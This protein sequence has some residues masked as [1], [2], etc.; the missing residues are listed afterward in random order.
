[1]QILTNRTAE[2]DSGGCGED[3]AGRNREYYKEHPDS[4]EQFNVDRLFVP[5]TK[6][7]D[8]ETKEEG[9]QGRKT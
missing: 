1:M 5:R 3:S 2:K 8:A 7:G 6:Q 4:F 9:R